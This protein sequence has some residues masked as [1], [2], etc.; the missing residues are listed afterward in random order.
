[1]M[2]MLSQMSLAGA[3]EECVPATGPYITAEERPVTVRAEFSGV[4]VVASTWAN[5]KTFSDKL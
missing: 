4:R 2:R 1:M 3:N 5:I